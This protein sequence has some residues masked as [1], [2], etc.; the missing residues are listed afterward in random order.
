MKVEAK[1]ARAEKPVAVLAL[2]AD[3]RNQAGE[4]RLVQRRVARVVERLRQRR[5]PLPSGFPASSL[6][7]CRC[8]SRHSVSR[9]KFTN[10]A[11]QAS[12]SLRCESFCEVE[13]VEEFPERDQRKE[14]GALV[15][16]AQMRLV[17]SRLLVE[18]TLARIGHGQRA[19]DH[20]RFGET[21]AVARGEHDARRCADRAAVSRARV[22]RASAH[23]SRPPHRAP[24]AAG[25]RRRS[26]AASAARG[27][28]TRR[29]RRGRA[30][31]C[32]GS[33][34]RASCAGSRARCTAVGRRSR[35]PNT[36]ARRCRP[37]RDRC[38]PRAASPPPAR[39][40][41]CR[42]CVVLLRAL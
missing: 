39:S 2:H 16:E 4:Q 19:R 26:R 20:Q 32:A 6:A 33:P 31:P 35:P 42:S 10:C 11:R 8:T 27:R 23:G 18:R 25:S 5:I 24:A 37:A 21:A 36:G 41:R 14:I 1:S 34:T 12:T 38:G 9:R 22:P 29:P 13:V 7:S 17:R 30:P 15:A 28:E 40:S 3:V